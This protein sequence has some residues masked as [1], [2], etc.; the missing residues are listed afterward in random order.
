MNAADK[1]EDDDTSA[2][3]GKRSVARV[4]RCAWYP[5]GGCSNFTELVAWSLVDADVAQFPSDPDWHSFKST[6]GP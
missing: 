3:I 4:E 5:L 1:E 6:V 2:T